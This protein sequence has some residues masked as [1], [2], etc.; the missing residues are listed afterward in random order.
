MSDAKKEEL[1]FIEVL[2]P[3]AIYTDSN[4]DAETELETVYIDSTKTNVISHLFTFLYFW[5]CFIRT[6]HYKFHFARGFTLL[7]LFLHK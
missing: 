5:Y 6:H 2:T 1:E 3:R 7:I 4:D